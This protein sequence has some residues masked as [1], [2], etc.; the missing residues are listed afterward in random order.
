[1]ELLCHYAWPG[2]VR[3]LITIVEIL[4][5]I[6]DRGQIITADLARSEIDDE[7]YPALA[8][9]NTEC[10]PELRDGESLT[11]WVCRGVL[12]A[13]ERERSR[14]GSHSAAG[15]RLRTHRN[16]LTG[17]LAWAREHGAKSTTAPNRSAR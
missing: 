9:G 15:R 11:E 3:E 14:V 7:E 12:A 6:A 16:T 10:F 2:N 4:A 8:P 1:M 17:W 5:A 13:Y